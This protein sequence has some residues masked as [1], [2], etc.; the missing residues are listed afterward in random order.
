MF[1]RTSFILTTST[2][3]LT[4]S[5]SGFAQSWNYQSYSESTAMINTGMADAPGYVT[6]IESDGKATVQFFAGSRLNKCVA[7]AMDAEVERT[8]KQIIITAT[9][10][11]NG[12]FAIRLKINADGS[13]G[14]RETKSGDKWIRDK[15]DRLL[16][17]KN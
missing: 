17:L 12:C 13:G 7:K 5:T 15:Q 9:P 14:Y 16:T 6:L 11:I 4:L 3:L 8:A 10:L 2:I 1:I